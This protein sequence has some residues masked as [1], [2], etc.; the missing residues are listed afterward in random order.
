MA[1]TPG[2]NNILLAASGLA[3]GFRRTVPLLLGLA[4]GCAV[5]LLICGTMFSW[6]SAW[7]LDARPTL[8]VVGCSYL[9]WLAY[10]LTRAGAPGQREAAIPVSAVTAIL[11]QWVNPKGWVMVLNA[12]VLFI[13]K[14]GGLTYVAFM[15]VLS[16]L[17]Q[18]PCTALWAWGGDRLRIWLKNDQ[19][20]RVFNMLMAA[21]L[22]AISGWM[23]VDELLA[24]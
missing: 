16:P 13:P 17:I 14:E 8:A 22:A 9:F 5:Q 11:V 24:P 7:L 6:A 20:L 21:M 2:P 18:L 19:S 4:A 10:R 15:V 1:V 3:F 23:L 12:C